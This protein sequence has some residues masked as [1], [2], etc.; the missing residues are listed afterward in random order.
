MNTDNTRIKVWDPLVRFG[1]WALAAAFVVAWFSGE[2][3]LRTHVWAGYA[4][5]AI[6][7]IRIAWGFV[8]P[9]NARF[10]SFV[11][12]PAA[13]LAYL[14]DIATG[15]AKRYV[16]HNPAGGAMI[17][18]LL[19]CLVVTS[20]SGFAIY[21]IEEGA[22]PMTGLFQADAG[23][24]RHDGDDDDDEREGGRQ[25][26]SERAEEFWEE[27]HELFANLTL[28]LVVLHIAGVATASIAHRENLVRAMVTGRKRAPAPDDA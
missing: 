11:R 18:A 6:V 7:G 19:L 17:A 14:R 16:G 22:G 13:T 23:S 24:G 5:A 15:R 21:A 25:H 4:V 3:S 10:R 27:L 28:A 8:G 12:A 2:E 9:R 20:V 1:H 26:G